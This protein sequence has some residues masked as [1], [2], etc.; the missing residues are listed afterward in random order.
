M[1]THA[2]YEQLKAFA[3]IDGAMIGGLWIL[4]FAMFIGEFYYPLFGIASL[5]T[6]VLSLVFAFIRM[7]KFRNEVLDGVISFRRALGY[8]MLMFFY[9]SVLMAAAQFVYFQFID[10]G[11]L[12]GKY[13][14][15]ASGPEFKTI[16]DI[17]GITPDEMKVAMDNITALRPIDIA[18]QFLTTNIILGVFIS[19]PMAAMMRAKP[20]RK[21]KQ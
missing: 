7:Q 12:I 2:E 13:I 6:G 4:S 3:R 18:L 21:F 15:I 10:G 9:A 11:F 17:Y 8:A 16:A 1:A 14:S 20:K 19:L 5:V